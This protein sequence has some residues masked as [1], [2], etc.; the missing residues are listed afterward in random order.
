SLNASSKRPGDFMIRVMGEPAPTPPE[1]RLVSIEVG[2]EETILAFNYPGE[3]VGFGARLFKSD[4]SLTEE[5]VTRV[6]EKLIV[7]VRGQGTLNV[8][9]VTPSYETLGASVRLETGLRSLYEA[10]LANYTVLKRSN[11]DMA[12]QI[13]LLSKENEDLRLRLNQSQALIRLQDARI[14]ELLVNVSTLRVEL[15]NA[16]AE[17]SSLRS[18]NTLLTA[19]LVVAIAIASS[20]ASV[21]VRRRWRRS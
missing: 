21:E 14:S 1:L 12:V 16:K 2:E 13:G 6:G 11:D 4:G 5:N 8:F 3:T 17:A 7:R 20:L 15:D 10:L 9:I 18:L 19:G